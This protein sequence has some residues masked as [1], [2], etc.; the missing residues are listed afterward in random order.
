MARGIF[1][2]HTQE[3]FTLI[4][5]LVSLGIITLVLV[6]LLSVFPFTLRVSQ[7]SAD[8]TKAVYLAQTSL[9]QNISLS[10]DDL[11]IGII[12]AKARLSEDTASWLYNF[13]RQTTVEYLD[14]DFNVV[15]E[16]S[17]LKKITTTVFWNYNFGG[18]EKSYVLS[19]LMSRE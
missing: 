16:D 1:K 13:Q 11:G 12:E 10:Y 2:I 6:A 18:E 5:V 4:E 17:G 14:I 3:G 9:E 19:T 7:A 8:E 15:I